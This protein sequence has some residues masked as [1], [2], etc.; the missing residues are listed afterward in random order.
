MPVNCH[1][2]ADCIVTYSVVSYYEVWWWLWHCVVTYC[3]VTYYI[4]CNVHLPVWPTGIRASVWWTPTPAP[5]SAISS[6]CRTGRAVS[7]TRRSSRWSC[8]TPSTRWVLNCDSL[9]VIKSTGTVWSRIARSIIV[10]F[11]CWMSYHGLWCAA[12]LQSVFPIADTSRRLLQTVIHY[13]VTEADVIVINYN[14]FIISGRVIGCERLEQCVIS[15]VWLMMEEAVSDTVTSSRYSSRFQYKL[16][17]SP[18][19]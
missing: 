10:I 11:A 1:T 5:C 8:W 7:G 2:P 14:H 9:Q 12:V 3:V 15:S 17:G 4:C 16:H 19:R 13:T 6:R 18:G